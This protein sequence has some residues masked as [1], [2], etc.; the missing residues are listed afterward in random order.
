MIM[1]TDNGRTFKW[2][3]FQK[4][5]RDQPPTPSVISHISDSLP[6][7]RAADELA[8][9]SSDEDDVGSS[10][11][12]AYDKMFDNHGGF[13]FTIGA[14]NQS[15]TDQHPS[16]IQ[17]FQLWQIYLNN[18]NPLLKLTHTPTLQVRIIEA[19]ANLDK[20]SQSLEALMF[21][22]YLM[23]VT[24]ISE[25]EVRA[26]FNEERT[27]LLSKYFHAAQQALLNAGVMRSPN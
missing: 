2:F 16:A 7:Y 4:E 26:T 20:V 21:S 11:N 23:A 14:E 8:R 19:S 6:Q 3:P 18:V 12:S 9:D 15:V 5:V 27:Q 13:P 24:S 1:Y 22:I 25:D 10:I 17:I